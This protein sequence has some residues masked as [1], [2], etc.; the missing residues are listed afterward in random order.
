MST[1]PRPDPRLARQY[2]E[3]KLNCSTGPVEVSSWLKENAPVT[4]VDVRRRED[5]ERGHVPGAI[6]LPRGSWNNPQGLAKDQTNVIY[7]YSQQCHLAA[8]AAYEFAKQGYSV[9]EMDGGFKSW[10]E[11]QLEVEGQKVAA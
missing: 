6:N 5:Y 4:I 8:S 11:N 3:R 2:F 10:Q 1:I 9:I 7:C